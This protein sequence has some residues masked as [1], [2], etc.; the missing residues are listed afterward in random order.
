MEIAIVGIGKIGSMLTKRLSLEKHNITLIDRDLEKIEY[1]RENLDA[2]VIEGNALSYKI[3]EEANVPNCEIFAALTSI[4]EINLLSCQLAKKLGAKH[5]I[6]RVR[7]PDFFSEKYG[8]TPNE[9]GINA[10]VH[11][12]KET[13]EAIIRLVRQSGSTDIVQFE[14]GKI[15]FTGIRLDKNAKVLH[16]PLKELREKYGNPPMRVVAIKRGARTI[17]PGG[18]DLFLK[19]DQIFFICK[20]EYIDSALDYF[21]KANAKIENIL[22]IG[23]G[24]IGETVASALE[25]EINVKVIEYNERKAY[26]L[27]DKLNDSLV[28][29]GDGSDLD[30]LH[31]EGLTEMDEFIAVTGDDETNI[32]TSIVARHLEVPRT[33]TLIKK[34][35]YLP[36]TPALGMDAIVSKQQITVSAIQRYIKRRNVENMAE[37]PGVDAEIIEFNVKE[38]CRITR[39]P[40]MD[41]NFPKNAMVGAVLKNGEEL[42]VP[43]GDTHIMPGDKVII[44]A[45]PNA[46]KA[47]EKMFS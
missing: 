1:A 6:A 29:K 3:L 10:V 23:G 37:L 5:T 40:L 11:P 14:D 17:I 8:L 19:G 22:I 35:N 31:F 34:D 20:N 47:V 18:D 32:I 41:L 28:I 21:G 2:H 4:D 38:K 33:I 13:A 45:L 15:Q 24:M 12:E 44:F 43:K 25:K 16:T 36:L 42:T 26:A 30:L 27:A 7:N 39:K 9:L 46:V